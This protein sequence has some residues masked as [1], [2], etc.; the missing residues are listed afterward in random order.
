MRSPSRFLPCLALTLA[1]CG[2]GG[3]GEQIVKPIDTIPQL[4]TQSLRQLAET[5]HPRVAIGVAVGGLF[6]SSNARSQQFMTILPREF[7]ALTPEND[8]KFGPLRPTRETYNYTRADAMVAFARANNMKAR[9][10]VLV[11]HQQNPGWLTNGTWT[12]DQAIQILEEHIANVVGH[13]RGQL[14]AWDVVNEAFEDGAAPLRQSVWMQRIGRDYIERAFRAARAADPT[15]ALYYNDYNIEGL[16]AKSDSVYELL[17]DFKAR[18]VPV[19]GVGMQAHFIAG[20]LPATMRQ[21]MDRF[22]ALGLKIQITELDIRV[23]TSSVGGASAASLA[24]QAQN[25]RDVFNLCLQ[26]QACDMVVVWGMTDADSWVPGTFPGQGDAL[27]Y[28][29]FFNPK[30]AYTAVRGLLAGN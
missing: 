22:A 8:L 10:H 9:G 7:N 24:T 5:R 4:P 12:R 19:D 15:V 18:G 14:A 13:Y 20:Q 30:P 17:R 25:Y 21:N 16:G 3:G 6:Q 27:L 11:W 28:D 1:A 26:V 29:A 2:G 23:P